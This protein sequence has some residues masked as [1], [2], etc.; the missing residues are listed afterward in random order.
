MMTTPLPAI[1]ILPEAALAGGTAF[2]GAD[3][4]ARQ[5]ATS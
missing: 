4:V 1:G 2:Q 3:A 5:A